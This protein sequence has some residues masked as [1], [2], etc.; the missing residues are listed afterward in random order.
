MGVTLYGDINPAA[1]KNLAAAYFG[2]TPVKLFDSAGIALVG[3]TLA[4]APTIQRQPSILPATAGIGDSVTLDLGAAAGTPSPAATWDFTLNGSS[5]KS[6][7]D[8]GAMT[9]ELAEAGTYAL[10]VMWTNSADVVEATTASLL[11]QKDDTPPV[12]S[13]IDYSKVALAYLDAR[14][15][16]AGTATDVTSIT[17]S[18]TGSY[19]F[20]KAGT[21]V[22]IQR[23]DAGFVFGDGAYVQTQVLSNQPTTD[24][25][26]AVVDV[27]LTSYGSNLGQLIDGTGV[28]LKLRNSAGSIQALGPVAGQG[29]LTLGAVTYGTR[30]LIGGLIDD[31]LDV[32]RGINNSGAAVSVPHTGL[33]D[34]L[35]TRFTTGRYVKGTLHRLVIVG[36]PEGKDWPV[37]IEQVYA[38]FRR[39]E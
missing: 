17:A 16:F 27:T 2:D 19:V 26:F 34:P 10:S 32:L 21:G 35:P 5:I 22:A 13:G 38:D 30:I 36:R 29:A 8:S 31:V 39:G 1:F 11:V 24:G 7:L 33:V 4:V 14:S 28:N 6:R 25:L 37:T 12:T 23:S 18:G 9:I 3:A 20:T 15:S